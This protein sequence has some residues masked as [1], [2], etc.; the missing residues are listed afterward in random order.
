MSKISPATNQ[1][2][3]VNLPHRSAWSKGP[4]SISSAAASSSS[5]PSVVSA[6]PAATANGYQASHSRRGSAVVSMPQQGTSTLKGA[7]N[8]SKTVVQPG[9]YPLFSSEVGLLAAR[10]VPHGDMRAHAHQPGHQSSLAISSRFCVLCSLTPAVATPRN[11]AGAC[12]L[13]Q[14]LTSPLSWED[15]AQETHFGVSP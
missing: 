12:F 15:R 11:A 14:L 10:D 6:A 2:A 5:S 13:W 3:P 4:P 7:V 9:R 8:V 1:R